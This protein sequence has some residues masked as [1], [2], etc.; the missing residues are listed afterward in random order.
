MLTR[1][2]LS[3]S[4]FDQHYFDRQ[5]SKPILKGKKPLE[6]RFWIRYIR[7]HILCR[8][9]LD[10]GC[11]KGFFLRD[12][13][14]LCETCGV[15]ISD[16]AIKRARKGTEKS[17][18]CIGSI[19]HVNFRDNLFDVVTCFDT[20]EHLSNPEWAIR[21]SNRVLMKGGLFIF[22]VP[23]VS[24]YGVRWKKDKWHGYRDLTHLSLLE[25]EKW[26]KLVEKAKFRIVD[27]FFDGLW[28]SPYF[29]GIPILLQ[30]LVF[31]FPVTILFSFGAKFPEKWGENLCIVS[32]KK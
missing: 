25:N 31:K 14:R 4:K 30:H 21:E 17:Y 16:F 5:Y 23:N 19:T 11:G 8:R 24:S 28:D 10:L 1:E 29:Y 7:T 15:D 26:I 22:T 20:L 18:L 27:V 32:I 6:Y 13:D 12:A 2:R 9:L 3:K